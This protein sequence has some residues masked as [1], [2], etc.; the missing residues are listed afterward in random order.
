MGEKNNFTQLVDALRPMMK[1]TRKIGEFTAFVIDLGL[2]PAPD[3]GD[4]RTAIELRAVSTWKGYANG[5]YPMKPD[6]AGE[7]AGRWDE[8]EFSSNLLQ[9]YQEPVLN[10]LADR[11]HHIDARINKGNVGRGLGALIREVL[12]SIRDAAP[13]PL[14][15][16]L[17][18]PT[19]APQSV[20]PYIDEK[21]NRLRLGDQ[22]V[23]LPPKKDVPEHIQPDELIYVAALLHAYCEG[24]PTSNLEPVIDDI[25]PRWSAHFQDQR[26][27]FYS[28]EWVREASWSCIHNGKAMFDEFLDSMHAGVT[29]TNLRTYPNGVERLLATLAQAVQVQLDRQRLDQI[30]DL[31][32]VWSRKGSCHELAARGRLSWVGA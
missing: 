1:G 26:K 2:V 24:L 5:S 20:A 32:D 27:A 30:I 17:N 21:T 19:P 4:E 29:D 13:S 25:P 18:L 8:E 31:I 7:L 9:W 10:E 14:E 16:S 6:F 3:T 22:S 15:V 12:V 28:A 23:G 11:L